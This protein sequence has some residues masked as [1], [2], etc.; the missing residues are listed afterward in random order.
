[1]IDSQKAPVL[2]THAM[3]PRYAF[4][5]RTAVWMLALVARAGDADVD[6]SCQPK[7][8]EDRVTGRQFNEESKTQKWGYSVTVEN[9][10]F[11][12]LAQLEV[13]YIIFYKHEQLGIKGPPQKKQISGSHTISEVPS[14]D[15]VSFDTDAVELTKAA[16]LSSLGGYT[17]F[18]NGAKLKTDDSL[19]GIWI[20]IYQN[21]ALFTEFANPSELPDREKWE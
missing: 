15:K 17:Y 14:N 18:A 20:R 4:A 5:I 3:K 19:T 7:K 8:I 9:K 1:M 21:G 6:V 16:L 12:P 10:T 11:K 2:I 13:K